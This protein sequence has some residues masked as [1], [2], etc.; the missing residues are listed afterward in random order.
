MTSAKRDQTM[1]PAA[2]SDWIPLRF[3]QRFTY[4]ISLSLIMAYELPNQQPFLPITI[5]IVAI[6]QAFSQSFVCTIQAYES[7]IIIWL[8]ATVLKTAHTNGG[9]HE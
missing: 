3:P 6:E 5:D 9:I 4:G 2:P 1:H 7:L 8:L